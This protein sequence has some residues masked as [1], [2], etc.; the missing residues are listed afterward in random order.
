[1]IEITKYAPIQKGALLARFDIV[2]P[3]W[4]D[5]IIRDIVLFQKDGKR[6]I[7]LPNR[8]FEV[9]GEKKYFNYMG[10]KEPNMM[11]SFQNEVM[12]ALDA[13]CKKQGK[14]TEERFDADI[15][16]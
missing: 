5:F 10:F 12:K 16:C 9:N 6:W 15:P 7:S 14:K 3:K 1:M 2:I 4:G 8:Q 13:Y 11:Q